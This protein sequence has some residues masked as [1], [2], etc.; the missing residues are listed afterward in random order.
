VKR[1]GL[2]QLPTILKNCP[3]QQLTHRQIADKIFVSDA[4]CERQEQRTG[5]MKMAIKVS[6]TELQELIASSCIDACCDSNP[7]F[8]G[9]PETWAELAVEAFEYIEGQLQNNSDLLQYGTPRQIAA[10]K[11][12]TEQVKAQICLRLDVTL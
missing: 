5:V 4:R 9:R 10:A 11:G 8:V 1:L 12:W 7:R 3:K 6:N 2:A